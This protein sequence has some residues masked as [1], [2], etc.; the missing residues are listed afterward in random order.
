MIKIEVVDIRIKADTSTDIDTC[1]MMEE[2]NKRECNNSLADLV[3]TLRYKHLFNILLCF[4]CV[5]I[6][7]VNDIASKTT[8]LPQ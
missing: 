4:H 1:V 5:W 8:T 6:S 2:E 3:N 7:H